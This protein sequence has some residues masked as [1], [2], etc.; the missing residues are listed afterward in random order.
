VVDARMLLDDLN[1][2]IGLELHSEESDRIGGLIFERLGRVPLVG[3]EIELGDEATIAVLSVE[4]LR[5]RRLRLR[6]TPS[7]V[8]I[9][10]AREAQDDE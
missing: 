1:D 7:R 6:Y 3:D 2:L 10:E 8:E 4:G 9:A 5:P